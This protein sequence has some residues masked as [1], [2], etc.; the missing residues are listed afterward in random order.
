[1][2]ILYGALLHLRIPVCLKTQFQHGSSMS[3]QLY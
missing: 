3:D 2:I 1:M